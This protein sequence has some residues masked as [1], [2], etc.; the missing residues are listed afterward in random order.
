M[1]ANPDPHDA[2]DLFGKIAAW[3]GQAV[4]V[5]YDDPTGTW[6]FIALHDATLGRPT[7]G[8]RMKVY[9]RLADALEDA[10]R[11]AEGMTYKWAGV[12]LPYGGGKAVLAIPRPLA[13]DERDGLFHRYGD[14]LESLDGAFATGADLGTGPEAMATIAQRT[15]WVVGTGSDG[16]SEDPGPYTARGVFEGLKAAL[17]QVFGSSDLEGRSVVVEGLGGVGEP[18]A[19]QLASEGAELFLADLDEDK[20]KALAAELSGGGGSARAIPLAGVIEQ[21]CD[22][23]A[24]CA[25]GAT[26]NGETI[27]RLGARIVAGSANNQLAEPGDAERLHQRGIL[28]VPDYV[29][30]AG[31]AVALTR[32]QDGEIDRQ[33]LFQRVAGLGATVAGLLAEAEKEDVSPLVAARRKVERLLAR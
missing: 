32:M 9:P 21:A 7:G 23:Y 12:D 14:L 1:A 8:T 4:V 24:P 3:D 33:V 10:Q 17:G 11:L 26:L 25:I 28:Y 15:G 29:I 30:N 19:R 5:R 6:I 22:V 2:S 18:L 20:A 31:G 13:D 16:S 27:P